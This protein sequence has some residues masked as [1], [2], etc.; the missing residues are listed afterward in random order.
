MEVVGQEIGLIEVERK[1]LDAVAKR[2][3]SGQ[4]VGQRD[5]RVPRVE[6]PLGDVLSRISISA[7]HGMSG[8]VRHWLNLVFFLDDLRRDAV[9]FHFLPQMSELGRRFA[10]RLSSS[11]SHY[12]SPFSTALAS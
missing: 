11:A 2:I 6:K 3:A 7:G 12:S 5:D 4:G 8:W 1:G 9:L 10:G